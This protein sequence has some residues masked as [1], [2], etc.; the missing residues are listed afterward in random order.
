MAF[1]KNKTKQYLRGMRGKA[2]QEIEV[3]EILKTYVNN[4]LFG[5]TWAIREIDRELMRRSN[6]KN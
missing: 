2:K 3:L 1:L 6:G 4:K 5:L